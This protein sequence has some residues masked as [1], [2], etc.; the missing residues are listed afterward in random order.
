MFGLIAFTALA[1]LIRIC[2]A[3]PA[4][5]GDFSMSISLFDAI[6]KLREYIPRKWRSLACFFSFAAFR[7]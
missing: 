2:S 6:G 3:P 5:C 7:L 4:Y 1:R